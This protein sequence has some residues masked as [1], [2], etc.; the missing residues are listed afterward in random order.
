MNHPRRSDSRATSYPDSTAPGAAVDKHGREAV[1]PSRNVLDLVEM[2]IQRQDDLRTLQA[3]HIN[4]VIDLNSVHSSE[5]MLLRSDFTEKLRLAETNRLDSIR[6]VDQNTVARAAEVQTTAATT[7]AN[8]VA[9]SADAVRLNLDTKVAP[10]LE[11]IAALQRAQYETAGGNTQKQETRSDSG[12]RGMWIGVLV[13]VGAI[14]SSGFLA[15][16]G[17]VIAYLVK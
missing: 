7:L 5:I 2:A 8:Q 12:N 6:A 14:L 1:D 3:I 17:I 13:A 15:T 9:T 4:E 16:A 10:I 11:A